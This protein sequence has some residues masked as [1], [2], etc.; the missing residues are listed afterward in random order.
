MSKVKCALCGEAKECSA[1][2]IEGKEYDVCADCWEV[3]SRKLEGKGREVKHRTTVLIPPRPETREETPEPPM[4]GEP[5]KIWY[6][7]SH[8]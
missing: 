4:P 2:E 6:R 3:F 5:P 1:R 7:S 8:R